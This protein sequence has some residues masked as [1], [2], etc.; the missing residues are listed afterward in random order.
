MIHESRAIAAEGEAIDL[1]PFGFWPDLASRLVGLG[2]AEPSE[3][4]DYVF[5]TRYVSCGTGPIL[6]TLRFVGLKAERG[7]LILRVHELPEVMGAHARQIA[8]SQTQCTELIRRG[9]AVSLA[10]MAR[11]NHHYAILGYIYGDTVATAAGLAVEVARRSPDPDDPTRPTLFRAEAGRVST[12]PQIVGEVEGTLVTPVSQLCTT[13]Q[14]REPVFE[15]V[16]EQLGG[17]GAAS[18]IDRW[19]HAFLARVLDRYDVARSGARGLGIGALGDPLAQWLVQ[20]G[21]SLLLT[22]PDDPPGELDLPPGVVVQRLDPYAIDGLAGFDF[23]WATRTGGVAGADRQTVLRFIEDVLR[24]LKPGGLLTL[25]V[26]LDVAPRAMGDDSGFLLRRADIDRLAL[27]LLSRGHQVAQMRPWGDAVAVADEN[28]SLMMSAFG[29][30]IR[31]A[32]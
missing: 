24:T 4:P 13:R 27:L 8:L 1:D 18:T 9:G 7:T 5:H 20:H 25:V 12:A 26:P 3:N 17:L 29:L 21:C 15:A 23:A 19:E 32:A 14:V 28:E 31:K 6:F 2:G 10:A 30:V 11:A 22:A 16:L